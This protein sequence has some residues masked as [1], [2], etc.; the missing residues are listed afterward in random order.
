[1]AAP[2]ARTPRAEPLATAVEDRSWIKPRDS[3]P[4]FAGAAPA[5]SR[6]DGRTH[7]SHMRSCEEAKYFI[8]HCPN[9]QMDGDN[10]G[11]P[12]EQQWC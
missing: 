7:C 8:Q 10:D 11:V 12:C 2:Q 6:C 9:T 5:Q 4:A 3:A 1:M